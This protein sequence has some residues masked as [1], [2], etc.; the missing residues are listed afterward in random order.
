MQKGFLFYLFKQSWRICS[1]TLFITCMLLII[2]TLQNV[3]LWKPGV[4]HSLCSSTTLQLSRSGLNCK[5]LASEDAKCVISK[6]AEFKMPFRFYCN[7]CF[8]YHKIFKYWKMVYEQY[9][10]KF[11]RFVFHTFI[12]VLVFIFSYTIIEC[13]L[14]RNKSLIFI[15]SFI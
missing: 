12:I 8:S 10:L 15:I 11:G 13:L 5:P 1:F 4:Y 6:H 9:W 3:H 7:T 2:E 14:F